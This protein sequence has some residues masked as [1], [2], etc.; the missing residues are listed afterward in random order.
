MP[1]FL[2]DTVIILKHHYVEVMFGDPFDNLT[3]THTFKYTCAIH[4]NVKNLK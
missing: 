2:G 4:T 3:N 1:C